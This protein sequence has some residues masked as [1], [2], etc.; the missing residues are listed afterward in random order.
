MLLDFLKNSAIIKKD[1]AKEDIA[2][3]QA[4]TGIVLVV[5]LQKSAASA[6]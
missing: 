6:M 3:K 4:D 5:W 1:A 2:L